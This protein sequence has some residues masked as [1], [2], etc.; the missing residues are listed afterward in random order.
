MAVPSGVGV[1][2]SAPPLNIPVSPKPA[3]APRPAVTPAPSR[4]AVTP[5]PPKPSEEKVP[6]SQAKPFAAPVPS[7][8]MEKESETSVAPRAEE[9]RGFE[10]TLPTEAKSDFVQ[11]RKQT[12]KGVY[13][14]ESIESERKPVRP[15]G[16]LK[17][18]TG[19][20]VREMAGPVLQKEKEKMAELNKAAEMAAAKKKSIVGKVI[21]VL[22][23]ILILVGLGGGGY[24]YMTQMAPEKEAEVEDVVTDEP[25]DTVEIVEDAEIMEYVLNMPNYLVV[26][27][28]NQTKEDLYSSMSRILEELPSLETDA[29][30][31]VLTNSE[32][33]QIDYDKF[34]DFTGFDLGPQITVNLG[35]EFSVFMNANDERLGLAIKVATGRKDMLI[36]ELSANEDYFLKNTQA[37]FLGKFTPIQG[38]EFSDSQYGDVGIRYV[39]FE[40]MDN[41][42]ID[43][44]IV[45]EYLVIGT[46]KDTMRSIVDKISGAGETNE[47]NDMFN[48]ENVQGSEE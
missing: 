6:V 30:E 8:R 23:T 44:A 14:K 45:D 27:T 10:K 16:E 32:Y 42:S 7:A 29:Y 2:K 47:R 24:Y 12:E 36:S 40:T 41:M 34:T 19:A 38:L 11:L 22:V 25:E 39:N 48:S 33:A 43:Y 13:Q 46:S 17:K 31:F 4:P 37:I 28:V 5:A 21:G 26:D 35:N 1:K 3:E 20:I 15:A 18:D 9:K